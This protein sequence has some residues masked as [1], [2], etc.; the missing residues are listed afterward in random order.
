VIDQAAVEEARAIGAE[1]AEQVLDERAA[2]YDPSEL[3]E[4]ELRGV[5][6]AEGD[7]WFDYPGGDI[8]SELVDRYHWDVRSVAHRGDNLESMAYDV[9]Q[10]HSRARAFDLLAR[11]GEQ[12]TA[13]L[14]SG[15][16]ND[17]A[18]PELTMALEH[19]ASGMELI[20]EDV[21]EQLINRRLK[22]ALIALVEAVEIL[23][24]RYFDRQLPVI[25]HGYGY[26]VPDGRGFSILGGWGPLPGPWLE[27]SFARKGVID[28]AL[29]VR[30][31]AM[32]QI[33][34]RFNT[35]I[36]EVA[37]LPSM[38]QLHVTDVTRLL[39]SGADYRDWWANEL[40]PTPRGFR[41]VSAAIAHAI[42]EVAS[43]S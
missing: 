15:G 33:V 9:R 34:M 11:R 22:R 26:P 23:A 13:L 4:R 36:N 38:E 17:L 31:A 25:M 35:M 3:T 37:D 30:R 8:L 12:P 18:G 2:E 19:V 43:D 24:D 21:L 6:V 1:L 40:H 16:G 42:D 32:R 14:L 10:V 28:E 39:P 5:L 41:A 27:P 29:D 20:N 7:S